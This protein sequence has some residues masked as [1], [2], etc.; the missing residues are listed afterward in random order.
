MNSAKIDILDF[1][2]K[3][4]FLAVLFALNPVW[5]IPT[6]LQHGQEA[7]QE[8]HFSQAVENWQTALNET[9]V[10]EQ[11][12]DLLFRLASA[13]QAM[14]HYAQ[15]LETLEEALPLSENQGSDR[16]KVLLRSH[17]GDIL[18]ALQKPQAAKAHLEEK[19][20][21]ARSL[22]D[23]LI[24]AHLLN[25]LGNV[26]SVQ[27]A[28]SAA[29]KHYAEVVTLA[30]QGHDPQLKIKAL[31]NQTLV[32]LK[33]NEFKTSLTTVQT[34]LAVVEQLP[35]N[36]H[37]VFH[38][39]SLGQL[40]LRIHQQASALQ[41]IR[42][43]Y[44]ILKQ[45]L[46]G[47]GNQ[48]PRLQSYAKGFLA[49]V[50]EYA[51]RYPEA[52]RLT[53]EAIF[54]VQQQ[55]DLLY[56][57]E[58]QQGRILHLQ[59]QLAAAAAAYERAVEHLHPI[60]AQLLIG[61]R[62]AREVF[63][64]KIRPVYFGLADVLL[65]QAAETRAPETKMALLKRA[66]NRVE[67]L[68]VVELQEYFQ[69]ECV[70]SAQAKVTQLDQLAEHTAVLYPI[71]LTDRTVLLLSLP[72]DIQQIVVPVDAQT[73]EQT[74]HIFRRDLQTSTSNRFIM[75]AKQ[76]YQWLIVPLE[77]Q[78]ITHN[79]QTLVVVPDGPLRT[80]PLAALYDADSKKFL[81]QKYALAITPGLELTDP[82]PLPRENVHILL[83]GLSQG[84]QNFSPLPYVPEE[85]SRIEALFDNKRVLLNQ[86]FS[87]NQVKQALKN[88][89]FTIVH[90]AS[91][92]QF[93]RDPKNTFLL[94]Y[95]NK[96]TMDQLESLLEFSQLRKEPVELLTLSACQT[97]VGDERA[98]LGLAGVA[99]KAGARSA[100]ASLWFINDEATA[101]LVS[102]FYT[103]LRNHP[104]LSKAQALQK[105]QQYLFEQQVFRHPAYW[106]SFLVIGNWL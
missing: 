14:G 21:L 100:L 10:V 25:N 93:D 43:S 63:Q 84:V 16:Q 80:I 19:L 75:P 59:G 32:Y 73:L 105:A 69:D 22:N 1:T 61:Q 37:K 44:D 45:A 64:E 57:W 46:E 87:L 79:I 26:F 29:L 102:E 3:L 9:T 62:D 60:Q 2:F 33:L 76:L 6:L 83:N 27:Q 49:Q 13:Y 48:Y 101:R 55:P 51:K 66:Q 77:E 5:A 20:T 50:Y 12:L 98:A 96:L 38:W 24:L 39:L 47:A 71:L 94:T 78:L 18:L 65:Q 58:W 72:E 56:L 91:H 54:L 81:F 35:L 15:A 86:R 40:A 8:G 97:A 11:Q 36:Y 85:I 74:V 99:I 106:S 103:Q 104:Q 34:A 17:L 88:R 31:I 90:I 28:Y 70:A 95:D 4:L 67:L 23:P 68:K 82:R 52:L 42:L 53:Q 92:G 7:F 41:S 89:P 30:E